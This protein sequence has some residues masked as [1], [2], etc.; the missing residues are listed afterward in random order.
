MYEYILICENYLDGKF[1]KTVMHHRD[2][3]AVGTIVS[4]DVDNPDPAR[5][6]YCIPAENQTVDFIRE[7]YRLE[8]IAIPAVGCI[9]EVKE[10]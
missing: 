2:A 10:V 8:G 1:S 4:E 3:I 6:K 5:V 9:L 7:T